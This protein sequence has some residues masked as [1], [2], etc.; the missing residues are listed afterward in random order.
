MPIYQYHCNA[1]SE[2]YE[3]ERAI[4]PSKLIPPCCPRCGAR[5]VERIYGGVSVH[6]KGTGFYT[7]DSREGEHNET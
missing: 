1:C 5:N 7:T 6:Y 3:V 2:D 4:N